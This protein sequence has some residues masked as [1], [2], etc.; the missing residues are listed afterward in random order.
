MLCAGTTQR[1]TVMHGMF[2]R[3]RLA[4]RHARSEAGRRAR[5]P[6]PRPSLLL[7]AGLGTAAVVQARRARATLLAETESVLETT[8]RR[9]PGLREFTVE[10]VGHHDS[11]ENRVW[12]I[13]KHGVYDITEF[14]PYHPGAEKLLMAAGGSVEPFWRMYAV[15]LN[16]TIIYEALE[17][18]RIGNLA[19]ADVEKQSQ[20]L[21]ES[22]D[23]FA[24]APQRHPALLVNQAKPFNAETP[25]SILTDSFLTPQE[26]FFVRSHLPIPDIDPEQYELEV[27]GLG[28]KEITLSLADLKALP[29]HTIVS[30][31]Q[32]G[33]NRRLEMKRRKNLKGLDWRGGAIGNASW[34]GA[35]LVDVLEAAGFSEEDTPTARHVILEGLDTDPA[36]SPFGASIPIEKAADPR[37][38]VLLAYE[39]NGAPLSRD[40]GFPVRCVVPGSLGARQV[41]W[42]GRIEV[43][44]VRGVGRAGGQGVT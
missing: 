25:L 8:G 35:R 33:G 42:L 3:L 7:A 6:G 32:C 41:K 5:Q 2:G 28:C 36:N 44:E 39:M 14:I 17:K 43:S 27:G 24:N 15:H 29:S 21:A 38:D 34:T 16:N 19:Q 13:F 22:D 18:Y 20:T 9:V 30:S 40:H 23:P 26:L 10:E 4:A 1:T 12:V 11:L 31:I 37:G